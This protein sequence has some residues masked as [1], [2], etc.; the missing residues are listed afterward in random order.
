MKNQRYAVDASRVE[1]YI[2]AILERFF[3][4][5]YYVFKLAY[6]NNNYDFYNTYI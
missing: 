1:E 4:K 6:N 3:L 5:L 2:N